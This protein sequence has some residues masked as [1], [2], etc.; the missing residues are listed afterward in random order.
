MSSSWLDYLQSIFQSASKGSPMTV[1]INGEKVEELNAIE[2]TQNAADEESPLT[3]T[4]ECPQEDYEYS[5]EYADSDHG[6]KDKPDDKPKPPPTNNA[7]EGPKKINGRPTE[8]YSEEYSDEYN[9]EEYYDED[10]EDE[11]YG[12]DYEDDN[13]GSE[14]DGNHDNSEAATDDNDYEYEDQEDANE[15]SEIDEYI[16][17]RE[18]ESVDTPIVP[19]EE[20]DTES[21][22]GGDRDICMSV[23]PDD[24]SVSDL[25]KDECNERCPSNEALE[26][27]SLDNQSCPGGDLDSCIDVCPGFNKVAFGL[28]V[29]E[30]GE[31]CP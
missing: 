23:C 13:Y 5:Y 4:P 27:E 15:V 19:P 11:N 26:E 16:D 12:T 22:P 1:T 3:C 29:A 21:C 30:C 2:I 9:D 10:Y 18:G 6:S 14:N 8:E 24:P 20:T 31:R 28:C 17:S 25:C 7:Q